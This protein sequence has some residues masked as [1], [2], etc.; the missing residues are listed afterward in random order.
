MIM[1]MMAPGWATLTSLA[2]IYYK[3]KI[4]Y[5][6]TTGQI[7]LVK[8]KWFKTGILTGNNIQLN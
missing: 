2:N 8:F 7:S 4:R 6:F 3:Q 1:M 5:I